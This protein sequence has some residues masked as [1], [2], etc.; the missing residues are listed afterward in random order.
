[1]SLLLSLEDMKLCVM[2]LSH[3]FWSSV[4]LGFSAT[5]PSSSASIK[6]CYEHTSTYYIVYTITYP[7]YPFTSPPDLFLRFC[8]SAAHS[9]LFIF[10]PIKAVG[11]TLHKI[12]AARVV[13]D[14]NTIYSIRYHPK[15]T[16]FIYTTAHLFNSADAILIRS[17]PRRIIKDKNSLI[18]C[19]LLYYYQILMLNLLSM[20]DASIDGFSPQTCQ[21]LC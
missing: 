5:A 8:Q 7:G 11:S 2:T 12:N 3:F 9:R 1:M 13:T 20:S 15:Q 10:T 4:N 16:P 18:T 17:H 21:V 6:L 14:T 19:L